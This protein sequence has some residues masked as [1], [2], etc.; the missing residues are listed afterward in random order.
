M[1]SQP[2][3]AADVRALD[4]SFF[5]HR[6]EAMLHPGGVAYMQAVGVS[7]SFS[8]FCCSL[9]LALSLCFGACFLLS[10]TYQHWLFFTFLFNFSRVDVLLMLLKIRCWVRTSCSSFR[11]QEMAWGQ[12]TAAVTSPLVP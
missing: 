5:K 7:V 10:F 11:N 6:M 2:I 12:T 9:L 8:T 3:S 1:T 4:P